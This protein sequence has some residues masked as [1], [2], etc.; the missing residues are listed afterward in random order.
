MNYTSYIG[1]L[2][3]SERIHNLET[4]FDDLHE[5]LVLE[6]KQAN[7]CPDDFLLKLSVLPIALRNEFEDWIQS[8]LQDLEKCD[9][10]T[11]IIC[12]LGPFF[13]FIDYGLLNHLINKFGSDRLKADMS[14]YVTE[15]Q[16]FQRVTTV[17]EIIKYWPGQSKCPPGFS[18]LE[19]KLDIDPSTCTLEDINRVRQNCC[20]KLKF[21]EA[22]VGL[23]CLLQGSCVAIWIISSVLAAEVKALLTE[24]DI[25]FYVNHKIQ[26]VTLDQSCLYSAGIEEN[27][28]S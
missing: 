25:S 13:T 12:H 9:K 7:I 2:K 8:N 27:K 15:I 16:V 1:S 5:R 10:I 4:H 11:Q 24:V 21:S 28:V 3:V 6:L 26:S 23:K 14:K 20:S 22:I 18:E 19:M 17:E